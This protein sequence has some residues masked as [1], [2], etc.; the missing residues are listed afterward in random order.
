VAA[1]PATPPGQGAAAARI[2]DAH[3]EA[4]ADKPPLTPEARE[5]VLAMA[6][7]DAAEAVR[8]MVQSLNAPPSEHRRMRLGHASNVLRLA[9]SRL[10]WVNRS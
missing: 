6:A 9:A 2:Y 1:S 10:D 4:M 8:D 5:R 3:A 7:G